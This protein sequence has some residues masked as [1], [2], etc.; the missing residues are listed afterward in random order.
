M[1]SINCLY[2]A[3]GRAN[4][5]AEVAAAAVGAVDGGIHCNC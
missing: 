3:G 1:N 5:G 4:T 2:T